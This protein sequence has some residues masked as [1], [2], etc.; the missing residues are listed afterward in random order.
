MII[1]WL[2]EAGIKLQTKDVSILIDPPASS[3][4][5]KPTR[6]SADI[7]A[8]TQSD[9]RDYKSVGGEPFVI[10]TPG[11]F[12][13]KN[14]F[15]YGIDLI[16]GSGL[17][18]FRLAGEDL[19]LAHLADVTRS[20]EDSQLGQ[21][22]GVDI[23][24]VPVGGKSVL[25]PEQAAE[26]VSQIE[27]RIVVP[28]QFHVPGSTAGYAKVDAFLKAM[29]AKPAESTDKLKVSKKDLPVEET[30]VVVLTAS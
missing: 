1:S 4:G 24:F 6:Q 10:T 5:F 27:P 13:R 3:T 21:F 16:P 30:S 25:G 19:S 12:E 28:I 11:E 8:I 2:G 23:L 15:I 18:H 9:G 26:L 14:I 29:G 17:V 22:E 20:M 7:V